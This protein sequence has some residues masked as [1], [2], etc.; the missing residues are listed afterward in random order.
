MFHL[1]ESF[2]AVSHLKRHALTVCAATKT[3]SPPKLVHICCIFQL[4]LFVTNSSSLLNQMFANSI[5]SER[6]RR[7]VNFQ[8]YHLDRVQHIPDVFLKLF[9]PRWNINLAVV[10]VR[11]KFL[12]FFFCLW[13]SVW[14]RNIWVYVSEL[15]QYPVAVK[16]PHWVGCVLG[17]VRGPL[18]LVMT[19]TS[20]HLWAY[21][22]F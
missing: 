3:S 20:W 11:N 1:N 2:D 22:I 8:R 5:T 7:G 19:N 10:F 14:W 4:I 12:I 21:L 18:R 6:R 17:I 16:T 9:M 13:S 15:T